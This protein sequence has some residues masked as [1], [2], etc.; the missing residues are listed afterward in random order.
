MSDLKAFNGFTDSKLGFL[1]QISVL[2][3]VDSN[4]I[5]ENSTKRD[6]LAKYFSEVSKS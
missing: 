1:Q 3:T 4:I 5:I 2:K 6:T